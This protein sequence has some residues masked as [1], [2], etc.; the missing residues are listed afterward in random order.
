MERRL[1]AILAADVVDYTR[2]MGEDEVRTLSAL[3]KTREEL[4]QP[5]VSGRN[6]RI[7]KRLGDGWIVEFPTVSDAVACAIDVQDGLAGNEL[8]KLRIGI[9]IGDVTFQ[10]DDIY[11]DG[12]NIAARLENLAQPGQILIS[13]LVHHSLDAKTTEQFSGGEARELKNVGRA[14]AIWCWPDTEVEDAPPVAM[15]TGAIL[16]RP[17]LMY[18]AAIPQLRNSFLTALWHCA[19]LSLRGFSIAQCRHYR[20]GT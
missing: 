15:A 9:H 5:T 3:N 13:D 14:M 7:I 10:D 12:I 6:G 1:A 19:R 20:P 17:E 18:L 11:G 2:L 4:F 8:I 16:Q